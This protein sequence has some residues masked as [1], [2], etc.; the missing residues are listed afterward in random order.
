MKGRSVEGLFQHPLPIALIDQFL[1]PHGTYEG[2]PISTI[3]TRPIQR[4]QGR[5]LKLPLYRQN[6]VPVD[7][8]NAVAHSKVASR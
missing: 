7:L 1:T 4:K 5:S 8:M 2:Q 3:A 6:A